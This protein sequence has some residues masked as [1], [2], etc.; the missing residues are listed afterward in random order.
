MRSSSSPT[1]P[2]TRSTTCPRS[3]RTSAAGTP[4]RRSSSPR[5]AGATRPSAGSRRSTPSTARSR[6]ASRSASACPFARRESP[7]FARIRRTSSPS[8][9]RR[10]PT[11]IVVVPLAQHSAPIYGDAVKEAATAAGLDLRI[12]VALRPNWGRTPELTQAFARSIVGALAAV[13]DGGARSHDAAPHRPQPARERHPRPATP[14]EVELRASAEDVVASVRALGRGRF[15]DHVVAF[16]SQGMSTGAGG[17]PIDVARPRPPD[18]LE[19]LA[20]RGRTQ[21]RRRA[22]RL[23]GRPRRDPL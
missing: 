15:A 21:R 14:Y 8:S 1:A 20:A 13:P 11:R 12:D 5:S 2:S 6:S 7:A 3:S 19:E 23:S 22:D 9:S 17:R 4:R 18:A 16:Q 10:G